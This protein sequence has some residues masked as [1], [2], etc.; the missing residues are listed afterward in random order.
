M[1]RKTA[2]LFAPSGERGIALNNRI[3]NKISGSLRLQLFCAVLL[4]LLLAFVVFAATFFLGNILLDRTIYGQYFAKGMAEQQFAKLQEYVKEEGISLDNLQR[5]NIWCSRSEKVY[6]TLYKDDMLIYESSSFG[7]IAG[8]GYAQ[9]F[10]PDLEDEDS[11]YTLV[12]QDG[13]RLR[14]FLYYYAGDAFYF[15]MTALA[16]LTAFLAFSL[17]FSLIIGAKVAYISQ[18]K[19]ELDILSGGQLEYKVTVHGNDELGE[20]AAGIDQMRQSILKH[21][22]IEKQMRSAN[23]ELITAMSH[24]LRTPLT[25]LLA[26]LEIV[27]RQKYSDEEQRQELIHKCVGQTMRIKNMADKLFAYFLAYAVEWE[28]SETQK[29]DADQLFAQIFGD[30]AYSLESKGMKVECD[31]APVTAEIRVNTELLQRALDNLYSNLLKYADPQEPINIAYKRE[32]DN[33]LITITNFVRTDQEKSDSTSI[34]LITCRRIVEYHKG[35]F[36]ASKLGNIFRVTVVLP[37]VD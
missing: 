8:H 26:Y 20:L 11:E 7:K 24:D 25:S 27:E 13:E 29:T 3:S 23:S 33:M 5:L 17:C 37:L 4:S 28:E 31:F 32:G 34:G 18:L 14:A 35:Y 12:L 10:D 2:T 30:Y 9:K 15:G 6:L 36:A 1:I 16:A 22:E 19:R 21:Q